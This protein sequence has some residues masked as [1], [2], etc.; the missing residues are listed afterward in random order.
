MLVEG[1]KEGRTCHL[2]RSFGFAQSS[3]TECRDRPEDKKLG[4]ESPT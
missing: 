3:S 4:L 1:G 2:F